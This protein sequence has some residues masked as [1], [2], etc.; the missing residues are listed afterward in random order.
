[1][2][3]YFIGGQETSSRALTLADYVSLAGL[4]TSLIGL[5][6][7]WKWERLGAAITLAAVAVG[8][9]FN[10]ALIMSP[11]VVI[12]IVAVLF[13]LCD[14]LKNNAAGLSKA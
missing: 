10:L 11:L 4:A 3:A 14:W 1:M 6:A 7:A 9:A 2:L 12:P 13:Y 5:A 8:A